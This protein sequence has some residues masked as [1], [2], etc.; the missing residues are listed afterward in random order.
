MWVETGKKQPGLEDVVPEQSKTEWATIGKVVALFGVQGELK[1]LLM[2]DIPNRFTELEAVYPAPA[3]APRRIESVRPYKGDLIILKL[4]GVDDANAAEALRNVDLDIPLDELAK[5]P[6]D[7]YYQHD[8]IGLLVKTVDGQGVGQIV[9]IMPTGGN[10]VYEIRRPGGGQVL[11]PA[12]KEVVK[13]VD[14][15]RHVMYIDPIKGLLDEK[16][17]VSDQE[18]GEE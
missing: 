9:D 4:E 15:R 6:P 5:L 17:A 3:H 13:Q 12:I 10:D 14:L 7:I 2:T 1:V 16:E 18:E 8:I 11:I